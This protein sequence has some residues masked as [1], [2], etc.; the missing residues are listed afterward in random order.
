MNR[1]DTPDLK[2]RSK[3]RGMIIGETVGGTCYEC[4]N[5]NV[6]VINLS[7]QAVCVLSRMPIVEAR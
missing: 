1:L 4:S 3:K 6:R 5:D 7:G 2:E